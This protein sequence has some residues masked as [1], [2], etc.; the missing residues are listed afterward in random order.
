MDWDGIGLDE[1]TVRVG[2]VALPLVEGGIEELAEGAV[3]LGDDSGE[4]AV[5]EEGVVEPADA[6]G[7]VVVGLVGEGLPLGGLVNGVHLE[8]QAAPRAYSAANPAERIDGETK[9]AREVG[10][11]GVASTWAINASAVKARMKATAAMFANFTAA[12]AIT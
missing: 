12:I 10:L 2:A 5:G 3:G 1:V 4:A 11:N 6:D 9:L 7:V 8:H